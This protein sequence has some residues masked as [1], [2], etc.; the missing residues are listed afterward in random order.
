[1]RFDIGSKD[2]SQ[3]VKPAPQI[4]EI[5]HPRTKDTLE[6]EWNKPQPPT[7]A[8]LEEILTS[9]DTGGIDPS[10]RKAKLKVLMD[11]LDGLYSDPQ[12]KGV[13]SRIPDIAKKATEAQSGLDSLRASALSNGRATEKDGTLLFKNQQDLNGYQQQAAPF[14]KVA[15]E[16]RAFYKSNKD[17]IDYH[18]AVVGDYHTYR[19][20]ETEQEI[21]AEKTP[22][23]NKKMAKAALQKLGTPEEQ[24]RLF[25][26]R[27]I[28]PD[29]YQEIIGERKQLLEAVVNGEFDHYRPPPPVENIIQGAVRGATKGLPFLAG[30]G[31]GTLANQIVGYESQADKME[32]I[33][34]LRESDP[35]IAGIFEHIP[36]REP[37]GFER[38]AKGAAEMVGLFPSF[39]ASGKTVV[40]LMPKLAS[41]PLSR[42][43]EATAEDAG[44]I[45]T[46]SLRGKEAA[47]AIASNIIKA[48]ARGAAQFGLQ[49][50]AT[51]GQPVQG[52]VGGAGFETVSD[53]TG[54]VEQ[55]LPAK[56]KFIPYF[57]PFLKALF[58][59]TAFASGTTASAL[60]T[61]EKPPNWMEEFG[62]GVLLHFVQGVAGKVTE[63]YEA[64]AKTTPLTPD[65]TKIYKNAQRLLVSH[66]PLSEVFGE[67]HAPPEVRTGGVTPLE[68]PIPAVRTAEEVKA[69]VP[70][71][72]VE[73]PGFKPQEE[74]QKQEEEGR[75]Q[76]AQATLQQQRAD[77]WKQKY[78][79]QAPPS[80]WKGVQSI[81]QEPEER[82]QVMEELLQLGVPE[83]QVVNLTEADQR[84]LWREKAGVPEGAK[85]EPEIP[86]LADKTQD[87]NFAVE[88][89]KTATPE[90]VQ[91]MKTRRAQLLAEAGQL[92]EQAKTETDKTKRLQLRNQSL[93]ISTRA[94]KYRE[95]IESAAEAARKKQ[96]TSYKGFPQFE[97]E[98][99]G[100]PKE[101]MKILD[102]DKIA[103]PVMNSDTQGP[104]KHTLTVYYDKNT[105]TDFDEIVDE[106][107]VN[108]IADFYRSKGAV[109]AEVQ[110]FAYNEEGSDPQQLDEWTVFDDTKKPPAKSEEV[111]TG[112]E[113]MAAIPGEPIQWV[114]GDTPDEAKAVLIQD[115]DSEKYFIQK[116]DGSKVMNPKSLQGGRGAVLNEFFDSP[117]EAWQ[118]YHAEIATKPNSIASIIGK[119]ETEDAKSMGW[120]VSKI[121][122]KTIAELTPDEMETLQNYSTG[123]MGGGAGSQIIGERLDRAIAEA[124]KKPA[125]EVKPE[126]PE[127]LQHDKP[128]SVEP[129]DDIY[130]A[131]EEDEKAHW[132]AMVDWD[133]A[134]F[135]GTREDLTPAQVAELADKYPIEEKPAAAG[136]KQY[137]VVKPND[138]YIA[139]SKP[140][141]STA[142]KFEKDPE[143]EAIKIEGHENLDL[144][145]NV[146]H[147]KKGEEDLWSVSEGQTGLRI[148][149]PSE[150][151]DEVIKH[152]KKIL[153]T[154]KEEVQ[155]VI[156]AGIA[157][158][159][160]SPRYAEGESPEQVTARV[161]E[162]IIKDL[163]PNILRSIEV[164]VKAYDGEANRFVVEKHPAHDA[165]EA[166]DT[167]MKA[168][169]ALL[170]CIKGKKG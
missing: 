70:S 125:E 63:H 2:K 80:T 9:Y 13:I 30:F 117:D 159:G 134:E 105:S 91:T 18:N 4:L 115:P 48:T 41:S 94:A 53:I 50:A 120:H 79:T 102:D 145:V 101:V 77:Y 39:I 130:F 5:V 152:A 129:E 20:E 106:D 123:L 1:M 118:Q 148:A 65:E 133:K 55:M 60:M 82:Q 56:Y 132:S 51:G 22:I 103:Y 47:R 114:G 92:S 74:I 15:D 161:N 21:I 104:E 99:G 147:G 165:L 34:A 35:E 98:G 128:V 136:P 170:D 167:D 84:K 155:G 88:F 86:D 151:R 42:V 144:F 119:A 59:G 126:V 141:Q 11:E 139:R 43:V 93:Q 146:A 10:M 62:Q 19:D 44:S 28:T 58:S 96:E 12:T 73:T 138:F 158:T 89:G 100:T 32:K 54:M 163:P 3:Q 168:F 169:Q 164:N 142:A 14:T 25:K 29:S 127:E 57:S 116:A 153:D 64:K 121:L 157:K 108:A 61:G 109:K 162:N 111:Q 37:S 156:D 107:N 40:G 110:K 52:A 36:T 87:S 97:E 24:A 23:V 31:W 81:P 143:A 67:P 45:V 49:A 27:A 112:A 38:F 113:P 160:L 17:I 83:K 124:Q 76:R 66:D 140:G 149:G 150:S 90:Q 46:Q 122:D 85:Q 166:I 68:T 33:R 69:P 16:A 7:D 154:H 135:E 72:K 8:D 6:V 75:T 131:S 95:A 71:G 137:R 78:A 26:G